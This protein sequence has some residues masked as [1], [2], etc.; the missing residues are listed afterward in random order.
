MID[1]LSGPTSRRSVLAAAAALGTSAAL[2]SGHEGSASDDHTVG[3]DNAV[4]GGDWEPALHELSQSGSLRELV[5]VPDTARLP[6][7]NHRTP[8]LHIALDGE[9]RM[10]LGGATAPSS[11]S[12]LLT[13]VASIDTAADSVNLGGTDPP[14]LQF[15]RQNSPGIALILDGPPTTKSNVGGGTRRI[16]VG[17]TT[18]DL[19]GSPPEPSVQIAKDGEFQVWA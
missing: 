19:P 13:N 17:A 12:T 11:T 9:W 14:A 10:D 7:R 18:S 4:I 1:L 16:N 3:G 2:S 15:A 6:D 8:S 5:V